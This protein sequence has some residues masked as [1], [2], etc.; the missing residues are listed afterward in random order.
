VKRKAAAAFTL[1]EILVVI[2]IIG[3]IV[4]AATLAVGVM[5]RDRQA[6]DEARRLW[7]VM[8]QAREEAELQTLDLSAFVSRN[9]Y[10]FL[11]FEPRQDTWVPITDDR[12]YAP[13]QLPEGLTVRLWTDS[14]EV[15]LKPTPPNRNDK[16]EHKKWAPQLTVLASGEIMPF[17]LQIERDGAPAVWRVVALP[18]HDLR[19][20]QRDTQGRWQLVAQT[21][22]ADEDANAD[23][24]RAASARR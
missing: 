13:R 8:Q 16:D 20:E 2:V 12:L 23:K 10:E 24:G 17:E 14:R 11:R 1:V 3:V 6:E 5:G 4:S 18:D 19:I 22:P 21:R 9:Y 7:A 15:V